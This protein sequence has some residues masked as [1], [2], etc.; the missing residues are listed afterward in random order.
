MRRSIVPAA[1]I[2]VL[3]GAAARAEVVQP[4]PAGFLWGTAISAFQSE[5]GVGAPV[6]AG[7]DWWVWTHDPA[8]IASAR[9]SGDLPETGPGF[10]D[11]Y[12][13][14]ARLARHGL[15]NG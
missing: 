14:D 1:I 9:V 6:D 11:R 12:R 3:A 5:M 13:K 15:A 2:V 4:F 7:T 8:N 10:Y